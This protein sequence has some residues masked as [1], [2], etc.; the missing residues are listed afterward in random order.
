MELL[1]T[2]DQINN[3]CNDTFLAKE[4]QYLQDLERWSLIEESVLQQKARAHWIR[5]GDGNKNYFS[6]MIKERTH[7]KQLLELTS[8]SSI[9]LTIPAA[10]KKEITDFYKSLMG[11]ANQALP[12]VNIETMR[13]GPV[14]SHA[15]GIELCKEITEEEIC[16]ALQ[17][18]N[19][20]K[21]PGVDGYNAF[22]FKKSWN[23]VKTEIIAAIS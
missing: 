1:F 15:Q 7:R 16:E 12:T 2:Q 21:S 13:K 20:D 4:K 9:K 3:Q 18:I 22:F 10:I 23:I 14:L 5:S 6:A 17:S 19:D 11:T 8:L